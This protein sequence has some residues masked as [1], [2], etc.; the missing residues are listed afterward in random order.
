MMARWFQWLCRYFLGLLFVST[1]IGKLLDNR[2]FAEVIKTYQLGIP[3]AIILG[4]ALCIS[5]LELV[6]G[7]NLL[8]GHAL[9]KSVFATL[10]FHLGYA[11]LALTTLKRGIMLSNCGCF[12]VFWGRPL[13]WTTVVEDLVLAAI[14]LSYWLFLRR[15]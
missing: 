7:I 3:E 12:G 5:L 2:G 11:S 8:R 4:L 15:R 1:A 13:S 9:S 14:S 6:I 10:V